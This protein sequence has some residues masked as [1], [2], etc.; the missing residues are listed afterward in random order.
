MKT[1]FTLLV[2]ALSLAAAETYLLPHRWQDAR[3]AFTQLLGRGSDRAVFVT[4]RLDDTGMH[5]AL[6]RTLRKGRP[7]TLMTTDMETAARWA[8]YRAMEVC[9]LKGQG[10]LDFSLLAIE[11]GKACTLSMDFDNQ[12]MRNRY[13]TAVCSDAGDYTDLLALLTTECTPYLDP[14]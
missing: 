14:E 11:G 7:V 1:A 12:T 13:G 4:G 5:R 2:A 9:L 6:K 10:K 3:H 8:P